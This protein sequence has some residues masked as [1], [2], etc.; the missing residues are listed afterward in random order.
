M[1][2]ALFLI[3][4]PLSFSASAVLAQQSSDPVAGP[5]DTVPQATEAAPAPGASETAPA[6]SSAAPTNDMTA[7]AAAVDNGFGKYDADGDG[8][9]TEVEFKTWIAALKSDELKASG[10]PVNQA[11]VAAYANA[12]FASA[13][14]DKDAKVSKAEVASFLAG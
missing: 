8:Q 6:Q 3:A 4:L 12:A 10:Q 5:V 2:K 11:E 9:L 1:R 14:A 7:V 13:D